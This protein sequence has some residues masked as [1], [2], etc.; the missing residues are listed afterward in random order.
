VISHF[1]PDFTALPGRGTS[2]SRFKRDRR[3]CGQ[4]DI[5][6]I[7]PYYNTEEFFVET[8]QALK[9]QSLQSW[10][11]IIVDDGSTDPGAVERLA[12]VAESDDR[13]RV[14]RQPNAGP[15]AARNTSY[16][17][18]T[19]RYVC[20]LDSDD[21][22]EPTYLEKCVWFLE[23]N[24]EFAFCNSYSVV[25]GE[26][27]YLWTT[28]F[29][30]GVSH[31]Q[32]NS[33]PP[34]SVIRRA[35][36]A[37][38]G[39]FDES[40]RFGH[41]DWDFWL[42]MA[43]AGHWGYTLREFLQWYRKRGNGRFEQ[44]MR[45]GN[46]NEEFEKM[47]L[48]KYDGLEKSFPN[49]QRSHQSAYETIETEIPLDNPLKP[50]KSGRR[51][52]FLLPWMV[53]GG[54]DRVNL[55]LIEGLV[56]KGHEISI[57]ATL[58]AD[59]KWEE[60]FSRFTP[61]IFVLPNFLR[62][63]DFPRFLDYIIKSR[64]VDTVVITGSTIAYQFLPYLRAVSP[65]VAFV[66]MCHVE[67]PH[68][69]NGGHPRFGVG[70][71][72]L[73]D[74][75]IVTTK[76]LAKWMQ[77]TGADRTRIK[78]MY[79]GI[80]S[81]MRSQPEEL[82]TTIRR[83]LNIPSEM[84]VIVFAGRICLQKRPSLLAEILKQARDNGLIFHALIIGSGELSD[85]LGNLLKQ[86]DLLTNVNMLGEI[87]HERWLNVL[88]GSD[89]FLMPSQYEGI[90]V[91][92]LEAMAAG[93]V[94]IVARVGGQD[95]IVTPLAGVLIPHSTHEVSDYVKALSSL[96]SDNGVLQQRSEECKALA[97]SK[98]S[99]EMMIDNFELILAEAHLLCVTQPRHPISPA[100][101]KELASLSLEYKRLGEAVDW[102]WN[103][104][105]QS[106]SGD[107]VSI[108]AKAD[109]QAIVK[110]AM[111]FSQTRLG[112]LMTGSRFLR[113]CAKWLVRKMV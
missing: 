35:A 6:I 78:V 75:N 63:A 93:V 102:L 56:T 110:F 2:P 91:A 32:A 109:S 60:E 113:I 86:H 112:M 80:R 98:L 94:P 43:K 16:N 13:I 111:L 81:A 90:S 39:G 88:V 104:R 97:A 40:I 71:Q 34:I 79:T 59:H 73:L 28:G 23:S 36:Y 96:L 105:P 84:P 15:G 106:T 65:G 89:I 49:P 8:F 1:S 17:H 66:D 14:I 24:S 87:S 68:W 74:L 82:R 12:R 77:K 50:N 5:S 26:Q 95:E 62:P 70:Y 20:L 107:G 54:A 48:R 101:G 64:K 57:C 55:D 30:R 67:E 46:V 18:S 42:G 41:E 53:T 52:L 58:M 21:M 103:A 25:F 72:S 76:H 19:G 3:T 61:D 37:E 11:W 51:I 22:F 7:T 85:L 29:E 44:V 27:E 92:L 83:E 47:I 31:L 38:V 108:T 33:G 9:A 69:L 99:W 100:L 4:V 10:E 45:S